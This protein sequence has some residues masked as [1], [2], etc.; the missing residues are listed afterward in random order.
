MKRGFTLLELVIVL[1]L[2]SILLILV[3]PVVLKSGLDSSENFKTKLSSLLSSAFSPGESVEFCIDFKGNAL[4]V[5]ENT[6][7]LPYRVSELVLPGKIVSS[8]FASAYCFD[9]KELTY[10]AVVMENGER[11]SSFLFTFPTGEV[12]F[13]NLSKAETETLKDK[14]EKGRIVEWFSYYSY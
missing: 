14:V 4:K 1:V 6:V 5:G 11:Y 12:L 3:F 10:G 8:E 2:I 9:L 13:Y 7:E